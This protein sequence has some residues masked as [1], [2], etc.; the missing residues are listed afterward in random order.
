[1]R[2]FKLLLLSAAI[3]S[4]AWVLGLFLE[5]F[6]ETPPVAIPFFW[7]G[8]ILGT[9]FLVCVVIFLVADVIKKLQQKAQRDLSYS[10]FNTRWPIMTVRFTGYVKRER[11]G[12]ETKPGISSR[13]EATRRLNKVL[14]DPAM[15]RRYLDV[16][17]KAQ[18]PISAEEWAKV[19]SGGVLAVSSSRSSA[20]PKTATRTMD[21]EVALQNLFGQP[22]VVG[23]GQDNKAS[24]EET[25]PA[26]KHWPL[27]LTAPLTITC[28]V[29]VLVI[30]E[31]LLGYITFALIAGLLIA[32]VLGLLVYYW[33]KMRI[34][35]QALVIVALSGLIILTITTAK[36]P[37]GEVLLMGG[38]EGTV[39]LFNGLPTPTPT[40]A[41]SPTPEPT[42]APKVSKGIS[43]GLAVSKLTLSDNAAAG[44]NNLLA[45]VQV[46]S[47]WITGILSSLAQVSG[48]N[49]SDYIVWEGVLPAIRE[50]VA[51]LDQWNNVG[52]GDSPSWQ[53][54]IEEGVKS[55]QID[56]TTA[57]G[58]SKSGHQV[59]SVS[60]DLL[61]MIEALNC[62]STEIQRVGGSLETADQPTLQ[63]CFAS[64]KRWE[65][66]YNTDAVELNATLALLGRSET[67]TLL[68]GY[69][70]AMEAA[71]PPD[72]TVTIFVT[73]SP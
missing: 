56:A 60:K 7:R 52:K 22:V 4:I 41:P 71:L 49:P 47:S 6:M 72:E 3:L 34:I 26:H 43:V 35:Y 70:S 25:E 69:V 45:A 51:E 27:L 13:D 65:A 38:P 54:Q 46:P 31:K 1:M 10:E 40:E 63:G 8:T 9:A 5:P 68:D 37:L 44:T 33:Q 16:C 36:A 14:R 12:R 61:S 11:Q 53:K 64:A 62:V 19:R 67:L 20:Q 32:G 48:N 21:T 39:A 23:G 18:R 57:A 15:G 2:T 29:G 66:Q 17:E 42:P 30:C 24:A 50:G 28:I 58:L 59:L 55:G 73:P